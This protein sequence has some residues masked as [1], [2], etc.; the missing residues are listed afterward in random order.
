M[1][2]AIPDTTLIQ[3]N[4]LEMSLPLGTAVSLSV[5]GDQNAD[6]PPEHVVCINELHMIELHPQDEQCKCQVF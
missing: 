2:Q 5:T 4:C 1:Y 6:L 3:I